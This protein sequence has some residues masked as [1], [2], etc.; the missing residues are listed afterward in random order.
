MKSGLLDEAIR[1]ATS[2]GKKHPMFRRGYKLFSFVIEKNKMLGYGMNN[3]DSI[4]KIH[5]G[6]DKRQKG[7]GNFVA[8]EHAEISAWRRCRGLIENSFELINVRLMDNGN[9]GMSCPCPCC[10]DWVK[11]NGCTAIHFTTGVGWAKISL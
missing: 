5:Y 10:K 2:K 1:V 9:I 4:V 3:R 8:A 11:A 6:Y 7:W